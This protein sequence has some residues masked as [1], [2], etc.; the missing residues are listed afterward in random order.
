MP[1]GRAQR[2]FRAVFSTFFP[3]TGKHAWKIKAPTLSQRTREG[4]GTRAG[5]EGNFSSGDRCRDGRDRRD[6]RGASS[7][8]ATVHAYWPSRIRESPC[9]FLRGIDPRRGSRCRPSCDSPCVVCRRRDSADRDRPA[10]RARRSWTEA[11]RERRSRTGK[12]GSDVVGAFGL[13]RSECP[14]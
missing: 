2:H 14:A 11:R 3:R 13:Q 8:I 6:E 5:E 1:E 4:W 7:S 9:G 12:R 10:V